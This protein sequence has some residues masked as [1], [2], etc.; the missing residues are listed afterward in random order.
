MPPPHPWTADDALR[1]SQYA[2]ALYAWLGQ[3]GPHP[4][5]NPPPGYREHYKVQNPLAPCPEDFRD[6][7]PAPHHPAPAPPPGAPHPNARL[8]G[9]GVHMSDSSFEQWMA[10]TSSLNAHLTRLALETTQIVARAGNMAPAVQSPPQLFAPIAPRAMLPPWRGG[11][12]GAIPCGGFVGGFRGGRGGFRGGRGGFRGGVGGGHGR[13]GHMHGGHRV[14]GVQAARAGLNHAQPGRA[15][16]T[17][18]AGHPAVAVALAERIGGP[19]G[20]PAHRG[21]KKDRKRGRKGGQKPD[22]GEPNNRDGP[23]PCGESQ[24]NKL[25]AHLV[26]QLAAMF[27]HVAVDDD[28]VSLGWRSEHDEEHDVDL[29]RPGRLPEDDEP[30]ALTPEFVDEPMGC[31]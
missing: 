7:A 21:Q 16:R 5:G 29:E 28:A 1:W 25:T 2:N 13:G 8:D 24:S 3:R 19:A 26:A 15:A 31:A 11:T 27:G 6:Q 9:P 18:A 23:A 12:P 30:C 17:A 4:G 10:H 20:L 14:G 22:R